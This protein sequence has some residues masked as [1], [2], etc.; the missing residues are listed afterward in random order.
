[1]CQHHLDR[2]Y[3]GNRNL[4]KANSHTRLVNHLT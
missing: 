1:V 3:L 2:T 4:E